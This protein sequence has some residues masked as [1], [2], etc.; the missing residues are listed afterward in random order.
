V[1]RRHGV[2]RPLGDAQ[3]S[4][5]ASPAWASRRMPRPARSARAHQSTAIAWRKAGGGPHPM[6]TAWACWSFLPSVFSA[7]ATITS[8]FW[9]LWI[10]S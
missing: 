9:K 4:R 6:P 3:R 8:H 1:P 5:P 7:G 10:E 2:G